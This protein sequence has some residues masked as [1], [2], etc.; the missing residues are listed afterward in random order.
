MQK[1]TDRTPMNLLL[2][3]ALFVAF[4]VALQP[5]HTGLLIH[6][7]LGLI[8][9]GATV[10]HIFLHWQWIVAITQKLFGKLPAKSRLYYALDAALLITFLVILI[11]GVLLS[12]V[13]LPL[14]SFR[15]TTGSVLSGLHE[16]VSYL[17]LALLMVKLALHWKWI[18]YAVKR[19]IGGGAR[20]RSLADETPSA[21]SPL[22]PATSTGLKGPIS[23]RR[24]LVVGGS[25]VCAA[26][27]LGTCIH[28][29]EQA[30]ADA[31]TENG[32]ESL[33]D[34]EPTTA[35]QPTRETNPIATE[36]TETTT[37]ASEPAATPTTV[38][39]QPRAS[40]CPHGLV[41]D[42]YPGRC[43]RYTDQNGNNICDWSETA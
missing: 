30:I 35:P 14:F 24:F 10:I 38:I 29:R 16:H 12:R 5:V 42:P 36:T 15:G 11:S 33:A 7:W 31:E 23:R 8:L 18:A 21:A 28:L 3:F 40:R 43:H 25:T 34:T 22:A 26:A 19:Y 6:E 32:M 9:G 37:E 2:D 27:L 20:A 4:L 41:N 1:K 39:T 13:A 17:A